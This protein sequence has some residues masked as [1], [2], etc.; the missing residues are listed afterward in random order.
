MESVVSVVKPDDQ[1]LAHHSERETAIETSSENRKQ[2]HSTGD[3]DDR[4][5]SFSKPFKLILML[6]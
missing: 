2:Q 4:Y 3:Y 6:N 1:V 5:I